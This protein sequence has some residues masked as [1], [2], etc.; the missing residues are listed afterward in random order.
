VAIAPVSGAL[1]VL[2]SGLQQVR[3]RQDADAQAIA[4]DPFAVDAILDLS[5]SSAGLKAMAAA[6]DTVSD[7]QNDVIDLLA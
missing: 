1:S 6:F 4:A 2:A 5:V 3:E 7:T